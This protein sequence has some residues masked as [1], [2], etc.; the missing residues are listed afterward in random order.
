MKILVIVLLIITMLI[1]GLMAYKLTTNRMPDL[2]FW[3]SNKPEDKKDKKDKKKDKPGE[4][5]SSTSYEIVEKYD[6]PQVLSE[7]S[8]IAHF[9][10]NLFACVQDELGTIFIYN[11]DNKKIEREIPFAGRGDYEGI[12][13]AGS[14]AYVVNS[15]GV[16]YEVL[17]IEDAEPKVKKY[18]TYLNAQNDVEALCYDK[19][20]NRLLLAYKEEEAGGSRK[21]IYL[22]DLRNKQL[23]KKAVFSIDL[24][25]AL[26]EKAGK[27]KK[28]GFKPSAIAIHPT[29]GN[30][31]MIEG[32]NPKLLILNKQG[33]ITFFA[34]L[35][36]KDFAQPEGITFNPA[37][38]LFISNEGK[39]GEGNILKV[40]F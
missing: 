36:G 16:I 3:N 25:N 33:E 18:E 29:E 24:N 2:A 26:F 17:D 14:T 12:A 8:D 11:T 23:S 10:D 15:G 6:L 13:L 38:E 40:K 39:K 5:S 20:N 9:R 34:S 28:Q 37:G 35:S 31:Y 7:V 32:T 19:A 27:K 30:Y 22:F 1:L 21:G 4:L